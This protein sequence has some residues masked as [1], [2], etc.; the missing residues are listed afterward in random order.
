ME[1]VNLVTIWTC[2]NGREVY[3][4]SRYAV[5]FFGDVRIQ[6]EVFEVLGNLTCRVSRETSQL[7]V[8]LLCAHSERDFCW[9]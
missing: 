2:A 5:G 7:D 8:I 6:I 3:C 4:C 9:E 1:T